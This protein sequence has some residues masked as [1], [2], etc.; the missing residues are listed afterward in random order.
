[1]ECSNSS[2]SSIG[3]IQQ[4]LGEPGQSPAMS[5]WLCSVQNFWQD[6]EWLVLGFGFAGGEWGVQG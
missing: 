2:S 6:V 1:V 3:G 4:Q 5:A